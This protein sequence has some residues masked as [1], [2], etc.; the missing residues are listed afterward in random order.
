M[1]M[2][3]IHTVPENVPCNII[4]YL[5]VLVEPTLLLLLVLLLLLHEQ[6]LINSVGEDPLRDAVAQ[7][8]A[9]DAAG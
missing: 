8:I 6:R 7:K 1:T 4:S 3:S 9:A 2:Y 5:M